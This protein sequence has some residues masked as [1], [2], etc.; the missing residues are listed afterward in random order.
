MRA[1]ILALALLTGCATKATG[2]VKVVPPTHL[3]AECYEPAATTRT[4]GELVHYIEQ[5]RE[6]LRGCNRDK[7]SL[8]EWAEK[9]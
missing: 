7:E 1:G 6:T 9:Q 2:V 8:R 3:M 5:L 4:N